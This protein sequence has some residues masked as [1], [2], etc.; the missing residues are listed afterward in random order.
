MYMIIRGKCYRHS[1]GDKKKNLQKVRLFRPKYF[2]HEFI[3]LEHWMG[4]K[5]G[6]GVWPS[7]DRSVLD[8]SRCLSHEPLFFFSHPN[9]WRGY[10]CQGKREWPYQVPLWVRGR[11]RIHTDRFWDRMDGAGCSLICEDHTTA[12]LPGTRPGLGVTSFFSEV[13]MAG[14]GPCT[15]SHGPPRPA[16]CV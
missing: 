13:P 3:K 4:Q 11:A 15:V 10:L 7:Q 8:I 9:L 1:R 14:A 12:L 5:K 2:S 16:V 6:C